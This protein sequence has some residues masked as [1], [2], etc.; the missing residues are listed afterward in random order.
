M[1]TRN[2][3]GTKLK[4][5]SSLQTQLLTSLTFLTLQP[6]YNFTCSLSLLVKHGLGLTTKSHLLSIIT[7]LSLREVTGLACLV[8][9]NLVH[10]ML[11][12]LFARAVCFTFLGYIHHLSQNESIH[13]NNNN[14]NE[15]CHTVTTKFSKKKAKQK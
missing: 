10:R 9:C 3:L 7:T 6:Q 8:L 4:V 12:A 11:T 5:L 13:N 2:L 14:N 15:C 1:T